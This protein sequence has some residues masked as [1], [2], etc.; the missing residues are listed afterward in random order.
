M[1]KPKEPIVVAAFRYPAKV[2]DMVER[3]A[4]AQGQPKSKVLR[5]L[6]TAGLQAKGYL[7]GGESLADCIQQAVDASLKPQ[8]ERLASISAKAAHISAASFFLNYAAL[9]QFVPEEFLSEFDELATRAR[10]LGAEYL[11]LSRDKSIDQ[12]LSRGLAAMTKEPE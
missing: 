9:R 7:S 8:V 6:L 10:K 3:I 2:D 12:F 5:D 1:K 4:A 11:K